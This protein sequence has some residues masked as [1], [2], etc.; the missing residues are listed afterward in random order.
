MADI[1]SSSTGGKKEEL[2]LFLP[3][4]F[5]FHPT[6]EELITHYLSKKAMNNDFSVIS[7]GEVDLN[8]VEPWD[9][10]WKAKMGEK[11]WYFFCVRDKKY[12]TGLRTNRAT[13]K[14][15][16][17][18]TGKDREIFR[19]RFLI[20]M[21]KTLVFYMGRA[22]KGEK[23]N[24]IMHEYRLEGEIQN[25]EWVICRVFHKT[26]G[27]KKISI[28]DLFPVMNST[29]AAGTAGGA[30]GGG[31]GK[32]SPITSLTDQSSS[33]YAFSDVPCFSN[34]NQLDIKDYI[35]KHDSSPAP[36]PPPPPP[37]PPSFPMMNPIQQYPDQPLIQDQTFMMNSVDYMKQNMKTE[38]VSM[39]DQEYT[40]MGDDDDIPVL[41]HW[42]TDRPPFQGPEISA[43][44]MG[45][46]GLWFFDP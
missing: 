12:P 34:T 16:W 40:C 5:R 6:D 39:S 37:P 19:G 21:K 18:A 25:Y 30:G 27:G 1:D 8:K 10:P 15:Y 23:S 22:P 11:E 28:S 46:G 29:I 38:F 36:P 43:L 14:G 3:P 4:G 24:W 32:A 44:Q 26:A 35:I 7:I 2:T 45:S 13:A 9:L 41:S 31:G 20:G 33:S 17:K 42:E